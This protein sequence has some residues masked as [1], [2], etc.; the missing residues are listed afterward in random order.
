VTENTASPLAAQQTSYNVRDFVDPK[1]LRIDI[2]Y[3]KNNLDDAM[4]NQASM[5]AHY[6]VLASEASRQTDV[7]KMLLQNIEAAVYKVLSDENAVAGK[8]VTV[9]LMDSL[10]ARHARVIDMK[11]A[12]NEAKR[13]E[14]TSKI[15]VEAFRHR[16]DMLVQ[17]GLISR[18]E[19]KGNLY[20]AERS[21]REEVIGHQKSSM[22]ERLNKNKNRDAE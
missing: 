10:V 2:A 3:S 1:Q 19:M 20:I 16:R 11:R 15:A 4:M 22:L 17:H 14:A 7:V 13:V 8:K 21:V 12:L 9:P 5:F 18:E 6:G